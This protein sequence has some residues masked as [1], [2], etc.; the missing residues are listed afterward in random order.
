MN[1]QGIIFFHSLGHGWVLDKRLIQEIFPNL[2][3]SPIIGENALLEI[4]QDVQWV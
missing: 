3:K 1:R 2:F 4:L